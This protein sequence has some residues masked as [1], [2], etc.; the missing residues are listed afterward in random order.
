MK[1][2]R[3]FRRFFRRALMT[4]PGDDFQSAEA[5]N[6]I[7]GGPESRDAGRDLVETLKQRHFA[8]DILC[9]RLSPACKG[10]HKP[11]KKHQQERQGQLGA[12]LLSGI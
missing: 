11:G 3:A 7:D 10:C 1:K 8:D 12:A 2:G 6:R 5:D 4:G 9:A